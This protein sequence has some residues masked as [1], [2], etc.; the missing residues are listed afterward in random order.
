MQFFLLIS[1]S[2][3]NQFH[4]LQARRTFIAYNNYPL[5]KLKGQ[6][7]PVFHKR[8][9]HIEIDSDSIHEAFDEDTILLSYAPSNLQTAGIFYKGFH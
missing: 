2:S 9:K 4:E 7:S 5:W 8:T 6:K 1:S 3:P